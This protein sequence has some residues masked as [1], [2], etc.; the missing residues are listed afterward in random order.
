MLG[1]GLGL[2]SAPAISAAVSASVVGLA[3]AIGCTPPGLA[4]ASGIAAMYLDVA[5]VRAARRGIRCLTDSNKA[6]RHFETGGN[7]ND[8]D[9]V[10][11]LRY[12]ALSEMSGAISSNRNHLGMEALALHK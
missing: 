3:S 6:L 1:A 4:I 2:V 5:V 7:Y 9:V 8:R 10:K 11:K 12:Q